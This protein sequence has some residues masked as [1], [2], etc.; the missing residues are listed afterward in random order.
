MKDFTEGIVNDIC[1]KQSDQLDAEILKALNKHGFKVD[2]SNM[3][4]F[5]ANHEID[6]FIND[7]LNTL[8]VDGVAVCVW[9]D[10][11]MEPFNFTDELKVN[12]FFKFQ[13]L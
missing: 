11:E 8:V 9:T 12:A 3:K 7:E 4:E 10:W 13:I 5:A 1:K 6:R 2:K